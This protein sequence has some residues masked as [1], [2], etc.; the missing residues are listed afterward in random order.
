M[1]NLELSEQEIIRRQSLDELRQVGVEPYPA[2]KY[3]VNAW[4]T[5]IKSEF[6]DEEDRR[7]VSIAGRIMTRRIMEKASF[8]ELMDSKGRIQVYI[9]RDDIC[10]KKIRI[11]ITSYLKN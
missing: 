6:T 8:I 3:E 10:P 2:A 1:Q 5:D 7:Q 11:F 9:T 4:S